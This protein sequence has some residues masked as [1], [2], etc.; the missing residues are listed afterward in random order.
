MNKISFLKEIQFVVW[1]IP[2]LGF[3]LSIIFDWGYLAYFDI[4]FFFAEVNY[5]TAF[6]SMLSIAIISIGILYILSIGIYLSEKNNLF[7][8]FVFDP[9]ILTIS[10]I[11][12]VLGIAT[13]HSF[14]FTFFTYVGGVIFKFLYFLIVSIYNKSLSKTIDNISWPIFFNLDVTKFLNS[15]FLDVID[16]EPVRDGVKETL[17]HIEYKSFAGYLIAALF[18]SLI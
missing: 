11:V 13:H 10:F 2:V 3:L 9:F 16:K 18:F 4:P 5:Y 17:E 15:K 7:Y 6:T 12:L 8:F 14:H 1:A